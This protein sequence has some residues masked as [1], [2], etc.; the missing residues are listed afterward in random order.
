M[1]PFS[2]NIDGSSRKEKVEKG[3]LPAFYS[4]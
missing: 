2:G 4:P 3:A 1:V